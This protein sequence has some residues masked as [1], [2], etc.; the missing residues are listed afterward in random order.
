MI[1]E[2]YRGNVGIILFN[3][4]DVDFTVNP[5]DRVAQLICEKIAYPE[6]AELEVPVIINKSIERMSH[7]I[8]RFHQSNE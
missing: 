1:D 4:S 3:H 8:A 7:N 2:D 6:L 5:G